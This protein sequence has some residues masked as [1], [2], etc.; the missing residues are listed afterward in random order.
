MNFFFS[1]SHFHIRE[2]RM[3]NI[4]LYW[5]QLEEGGVFVVRLV[6]IPPSVH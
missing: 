1:C 4:D 3:T 6:V 5:M 2:A